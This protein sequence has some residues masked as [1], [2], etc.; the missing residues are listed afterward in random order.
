[1]MFFQSDETQNIIRYIKETYNHEPQFLWEKFPCNAVFRHKYNKKWY[2]VLINLSKRKLGIEK[3]GATDILVVKCDPL[4]IGSLI[5]GEKYFPAYHMN[6][7][8][9]I[10]IVIDKTTIDEIAH[11]IDMSYE[12][13]KKK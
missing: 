12:I 8:H 6:K 3:D 4:L 10:T 5:D 1:M 2:A 11:M 9:W 13:T 7:E